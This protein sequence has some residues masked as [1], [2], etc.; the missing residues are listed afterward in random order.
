MK[1]IVAIDSLKG[2]LTSI[3][4]GYAIKKGIARAIDAEVIVKPMADG[5]EG[6]ME[7][8][9]EGMGGEMIP[10]MV[11]GPFGKP[12]KA[13]YGYLDSKKMA[14]IEM[15]SA[16]GITLV[17]QNQLDPLFASTY[18]VG[19]LILHA[20]E[21][22]ARDFIIGIGGSATND[23]GA[24][25]LSALGFQFLN[26][27]GAPIERGA[28]GLSK[29]TV[30]RDDKVNANLLNCHFKVACDVTNP[31]CGIN[32]AT[33][34]YGPQKGAKPEQLKIID[35]AMEHYADKT[36]ELT[37][38]SDK[39]T[40]GA[41]AAGGMGFAFLSYLNADLK[42]G[43]DVVMEA[44]GLDTCLTGADFVVTGE[45]RLD[46][47]TAMGKAPVGVAK[48]AAGKGVKVIALAGSVTKDASA[49]NDQGICAYFPII[50]GILTLEEAMQKET[51]AEN[52]QN[53]AEQVFRL[54]AAI[55]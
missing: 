46:G 54:V 19:Q 40:P 5:G 13:C 27:D 36:A 22:G 3:E 37:G 30:I 33:Y 8:I 10:A 50:P 28:K 45:G 16:A 4:A 52:L 51:A 42:P 44:V 43:I 6:T 26:Q 7:A 47:Q 12:T 55:Q 24:G 14:V 21:R 25:M 32:G 18:G 17:N 23:G 9:V 48:L 31:L 11:E 35:T 29:I 34:I 1:I 39:E 41:G 38:R 15:A 2:S 20:I 53:T 49:C